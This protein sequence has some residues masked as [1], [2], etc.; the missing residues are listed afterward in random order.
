MGLPCFAGLSL[1]VVGYS[2]VGNTLLCSVWISHNNDFS[3]CR[4]WALG[5][6]S[7]SS[8]NM[9]LLGPWTDPV[10]L[11]SQGGFLITGTPGKLSTPRIYHLFIFKQ[12][13]DFYFTFW[14]LKSSF[15]RLT[16]ISLNV[17][18]DQFWWYSCLCNSSHCQNIK[19]SIIR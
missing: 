6:T 7:F 15:H 10:S 3:C 13:G 19:I 2:R 9:R 17:L 16:C 11:A 12:Q 1:V 4:A 8:S 5:L 14:R 18:F